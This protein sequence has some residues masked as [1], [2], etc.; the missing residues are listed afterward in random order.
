MDCAF[1]VL[2]RHN[3]RIE[4]LGH[5]LYAERGLFKITNIHEKLGQQKDQGSK[6]DDAFMGTNL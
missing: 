2:A 3:E 4:R 5:V 1:D 6:L